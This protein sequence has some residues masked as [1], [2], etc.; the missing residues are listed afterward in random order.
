MDTDSVTVIKR[1]HENDPTL[2]LLCVDPTVLEHIIDQSC[3]YKIANKV[4]I[5]QL[6]YWLSVLNVNLRTFTTAIRARDVNTPCFTKWWPGEGFCEAIATNTTLRHLVVDGDAFGFLD[7]TGKADEIRVSEET[8]LA[9]AL[10]NNTTLQTLFIGFDDVDGVWGETLKH[11]LSHDTV[12][13]TLI[14]RSNAR[15]NEG[16]L[17]MFK[18][19][20]L[21]NTLTKLN[22]EGTWIDDKECIRLARS[23]GTNTTLVHVEIPNNRILDKGVLALSR[24]LVV[25]STLT[26][27]DISN[28]CIT[29]V[30]I[31]RLVDA[32][33]I[34]TTLTALKF[35]NTYD[36][37]AT[38]VVQRIL[39]HN[40]TVRK[41][42][43]SYH[44]NGDGHHELK[45]NKI[46]WRLKNVTFTELLLRKKPNPSKQQRT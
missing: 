12:L 8:K 29:P 1:L 42:F 19:L 44:I 7:H 4:D 3:E 15:L 5:G 14:M 6:L 20:A 17:D 23:L 26:Y 21:N 41:L 38:A 18:G 24:A 32:L 27:L 25:N 16:L 11:M 46:L 28:N 39:K 43:R 33:T 22:L 35:L 37:D 36:V 9:H 2:T 45:R 10:R 34:N 31:N 30:G 40:G 13:T